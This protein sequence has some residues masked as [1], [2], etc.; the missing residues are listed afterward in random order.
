MRIKH[1]KISKI[2]QFLKEKENFWVTYRLGALGGS[3]EPASAT[4]PTVREITE[5]QS[6]SPSSIQKEAEFRSPLSVTQKEVEQKSPVVAAV[7]VEVEQRLPP[8]PANKIDKEG[9]SPPTPPAKEEAEQ[10][11]PPVVRGATGKQ[12][13]QREKDGAKKAGPLTLPALRAYL[14]AGSTT[15]SAGTRKNV[16]RKRFP[17]KGQ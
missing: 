2:M 14:T 4:L 5:Q 13:P 15:A 12:R 16:Y 9:N 8:P 3:E 1:I 6:S 11:S 10:Q 17:L 7:K